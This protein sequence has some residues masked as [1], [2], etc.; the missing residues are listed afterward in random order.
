[1][2]TQD[3]VH[4]PPA[5]NSPADYSVCLKDGTRS[6]QGCWTCRLRK[7]KCDE[8]HPSCS[9]CIG[10]KL[11]CYGYGLRPDWM[12]G[13]RLQQKQAIHVKHII[14]QN[15]K[16]Q[17]YRDLQRGSFLQVTT[18]QGNLTSPP[19]VATSVASSSPGGT[20]PVGLSDSSREYVSFEASDAAPT[21]CDP[22]MLDSLHN[23]YVAPQDP[24]L[25]NSNNTVQLL[26]QRHNVCLESSLWSIG[27]IS[28]LQHYKPKSVRVEMNQEISRQSDRSTSSQ[29]NISL[30]EGST[31]DNQNNRVPSGK[32][33]SILAHI[34]T[35]ILTSP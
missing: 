35:P 32:E 8:S 16:K 33:Y 21:G 9:T 24:G 3:S 29:V 10:L 34:R 18:L 14:K 27:R 13:G 4:A 6:R 25:N 30:V 22:L 1:M 12:D 19:G 17:W 2:S 31:G 11:T 5:A 26:S 7:K 23:D 15:S 28:E 20:H